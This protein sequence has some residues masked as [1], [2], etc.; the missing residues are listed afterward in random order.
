MDPDQLIQAL[1]L[2]PHREGG[3]F[4]RTYESKL[5]I[6]ITNTGEDDSKREV[7]RLIMTSIYYLLTSS[8]P[9]IVLGRNKS[10]VI[11][12][13]H[14]GSPVDFII[15]RPDGRLVRETLG[16]EILSGQKLQVVIEGGSW[17]CACIHDAI[18]QETR[19]EGFT[20]TSE[21]VAPG[22]D[23]D[24]NHMATEEEIKRELPHLW[25]ELR[26]FIAT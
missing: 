26:T 21:A 17:R 10:D 4:R 3:Y 24:D 7:Q 25:D 16:P 8:N 6:P 20:L 5:S 13:Y 2:A 22:F 11:H 1:Q 9:K 18:K 12:Y 14:L 23:Y 15:V 19:G